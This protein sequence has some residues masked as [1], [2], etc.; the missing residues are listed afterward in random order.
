MAKKAT[1]RSAVTGTTT[2]RNAPIMNAALPASTG[3][4]RVLPTYQPWS[5]K[6]LET[7]SRSRD[8]VQISR[9]L[10]EKIPVLSYC[11]STL[12]KE[13]VGKGIGL[14]S[15]SANPEFKAAATAL[16]KAWADSRAVDLRKEGTAY[17]LQARWLSTILGDGECFVQKVADNT[18]LLTTDGK[19]IGPKSWSLAD[20]NRRRLQLQ[21]ML[22]DQLTSS[23]ITQAEAK[24]S[25]WIDGLQ[26][27][28]LDQLINLR[29]ITGDTTPGGTPSTLLV[30]AANVFHLKQNRRFNQC[31]GDPFI[32]QSNEDLLDVLDLK[33][34][35]KHAAKIR[36]ALLGATTTRDGKV[37]NAMQQAMAA[38]K[39]GNPA[40]DTGKRFMEI[41]DG[42]VMIPLA[43]GETMA[44]FQ[45]GEGIPFKQ[46][47]EDLTHPF[48][49]GLGYPV[50]WIFGMGT[51]GGTAFRGII[52]KVRRAHENLR[53]LLY[54][55][56]QWTWEWVIADAMM[57]GGPLAKFATVTDWNEIDFVTDPD[58]SVDLGRDHKADM[59]RIGENLLTAEDLVESR[60]GGSG[61]AT[62]HAAIDEKLDNL[63]YA[64]HRATGKAL[65]Q[66]TIPESIALIIGLGQRASQAASGLVS[67]LTPEALA[68]ELTTRDQQ[69]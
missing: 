29:V 44:F 58:P 12:P 24:A 39:T 14:K 49:F 61:T 10:Q 7:M 63:R 45:G 38:E 62:R 68:A 59:E 55:F 15:T 31:H 11:I 20:K 2:I 3:T 9:F 40:T 4:Y 16:Y 22:R 66:I 18:E 32:F 8:R 54:P 13:A 30:S 25:R 52:E 47:L 41:A 5:S 27:N 60:T 19:D 43:D 26:Y 37:P 65:D 56:L 1:R 67:S 35:R 53:A 51:L 34:I 36:S 17:E 48:V 69:V 6:Q 21:T 23:G 42:A 46:I 50:E 64:I 28:A 57:P 33:A